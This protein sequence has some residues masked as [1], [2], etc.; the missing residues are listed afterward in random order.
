MNFNKLKELLLKDK[1]DIVDVHN[2][3]KDATGA[4]A[5]DILFYNAKKE[6]FFDKINKLS[7]HLKY[8]DDNSITGCSLINKHSLFISNITNDNKY[9][10][11]IDNPFKLDIENQIVIP[12]FNDEDIK[13]IIR[14]SQLPLA[15]DEIDFADMITL[16][17]PFKLILGD[18]ITDTQSIDNEVFTDRL[19]IF[20]TVNEIKKL[21]DILSQNSKEQEVEKLIGYGRENINNIFT[22]LNPSLRHIAKVKKE[23]LQVQNLQS[24]DKS[25][26]ILIA[27][28]V[29]INVN[30]L[31]AMLSSNKR[32]DKIKL[33]YDGI[34]T[35]D[36]IENCVDC[37]DNIHI[38]FLDHHMPGVLGTDVAR[39]IKSKEST[40]N[41]II[42]VSITNDI[43]I[44]EANR[45]IYDYHLP[46]PFTKNNINKIMTMI[47][48]VNK[49]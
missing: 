2:H 45:D 10:L 43:E 23:I 3:I 19:A 6:V 38:I 27:D 40:H 8:L 41:K 5:V 32:I 36:V 31:K 13:G 15:F 17:E 33:A 11:A 7:L 42:I 30:I 1:R 37:A 39:K 48:E 22:Y 29:K 44:M 46:K 16:E 49:L 28:D 35:I 25:I 21:L 18:K 47:K 14:L 26:N 24:V 12:I 4:K 9:N 34:E 20:N